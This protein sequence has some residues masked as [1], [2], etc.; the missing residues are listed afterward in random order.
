MA[1]T[2]KNISGQ[3]VEADRNVTVQKAGKDVVKKVRDI[4]QAH[5]ELVVETEDE[6]A[7]WEK[8]PNI[9]I[10]QNE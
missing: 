7:E 6:I 5:G 8:V 9:V 10:T 4:I 1:Y 2:I 3:P